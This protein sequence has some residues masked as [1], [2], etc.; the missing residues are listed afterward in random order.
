MLVAISNSFIEQNLHHY[1]V[2]IAYH[3]DELNQSFNQSLKKT[4][5]G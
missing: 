4:A 2:C 1:E 5:E 3:L